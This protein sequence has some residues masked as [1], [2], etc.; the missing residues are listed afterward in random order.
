MVSIIAT[1]VPLNLGRFHGQIRIVRSAQI[2]ADGEQKAAVSFRWPRALLKMLVR[3]SAKIAPQAVHSKKG[4]WV[5]YG[6]ALF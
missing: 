4:A 3:P 5:D 1:L 6:C 2:G